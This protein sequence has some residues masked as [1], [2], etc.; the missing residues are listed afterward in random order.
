MMLFEIGYATLQRIFNISLSDS[1][2]NIIIM[3]RYQPSVVISNIHQ[4]CRQWLV[5][6]NS[7]QVRKELRGNSY[8]ALL[9]P[10]TASLKLKQYWTRIHWA[11][12]DTLAGLHEQ[13]TVQT[14]EFRRAQSI[15][16]CVCSLL[17]PRFS[18]SGNNT[19]PEKIVSTVF[20]EVMQQFYIVTCRQH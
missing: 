11:G 18:P 14:L 15:L 1:W 3:F 10:C 2:S 6:W 20:L 19:K 9:S 13:K 4:F 12:S 8:E 17:L 5:R 16:I 7:K